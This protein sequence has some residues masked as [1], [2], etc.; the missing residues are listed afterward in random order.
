MKTL[1]VFIIGVVVGTVGLDVTI[2]LAKNGVA[3]VQEV[4]KDAAKDYK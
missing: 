3:K 1:F 4:A 2:G